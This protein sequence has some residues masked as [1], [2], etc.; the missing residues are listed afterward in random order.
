MPLLF[1]TAG[2]KMGFSCYNNY[3]RGVADVNG[4]IQKALVCTEK[5]H[6]NVPAVW[7][8]S[9]TLGDQRHWEVIFNVFVAWQLQTLVGV[10][11]PSHSG[12]KFQVWIVCLSCDGH[13]EDSVKP[14]LSRTGGKCRVPFVSFSV[15]LE[16]VWIL[17]GKGLLLYAIWKLIQML[18]NLLWLNLQGTIL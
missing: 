7:I 3:G 15:Y 9:G 12:I 1:G 14:K 17:S 6:E 4:R 11:K 8:S 16:V 13:G 5:F 18:R 10:C 2:K